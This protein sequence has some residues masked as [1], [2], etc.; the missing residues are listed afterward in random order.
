MRFVPIKTAE[1][2]GAT[3][4]MKI[5]LASGPSGDAA[6]QRACV[7]TCTSLELLLLRAR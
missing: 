7:R 6:D 2:Q 3:M 5:L 1:Q 4:L